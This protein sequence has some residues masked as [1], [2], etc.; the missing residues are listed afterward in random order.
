MLA[1]LPPRNSTIMMRRIAL[2]LLLLA[3]AP[4]CGPGGRAAE[5]LVRVRPND[6]RTPVGHADN[7]VLVVPLVAMPARWSPAA[8]TGPSL[9]IAALAVEGEAPLM[10]GPLVRATLGTR[11]RMSVRN[12]LSDTLVLCAVYSERCAPRDTVPI[13]PGATH[14]MEFVADRPGAFLYHAM[15]LR[16]GTNLTDRVG[17][18]RLVGTLIVDSA[19]A[20][21]NAAERVMVITSWSK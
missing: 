7:G 3:G 10:P 16:H 12:S 19:N 14:T 17:N 2:I 1:V 21:P 11:V 4:S 13:L 8:D 15:R 9:A 5:H 6:N 20:R 18:T